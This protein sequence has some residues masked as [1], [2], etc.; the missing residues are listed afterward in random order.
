K[1]TLPV[2]VEKRVFND[3]SQIGDW[4]KDKVYSLQLA[5]IIDGR[6]NGMFAPTASATRAEVSKMLDYYLQLIKTGTVE[7]TI[8]ETGTYGTSGRG[9]NLT[10]TSI[11][12]PGY[13]HTAIFVFEQHGFEDSYNR[14]G[15][16]LVDLAKE[17]ISFLNSNID[18]LWDCRVIIISSANPDGLAEGTTKNGPGRCTVAN[19]TDMNR[20]WPTSNYEPQTSNPRYYSPYALSCPET[21]NLKQLISRENPSV[22]LD[23][24]GWLN[25]SYGNQTL[26]YIF[27]ENMGLP[28][29]VLFS[30]SAGL[31]ANNVTY[32]PQQEKEMAF[33]SGL[34]G[35]KGYLAGYGKEQGMYSALIELPSPYNIN[36][37]GF[38]KAIENSIYLCSQS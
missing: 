1:I 29:K 20:D 14:D 30:S 13:Q 5:G 4:A 37:S 2:L 7:K 11:Y 36:K 35:F 21:R 25:G 6:E 26:A 3:D 23:I 10:Y 34:V 31:S 24:H 18:R 28:Y 15:Q 8:V 33:E 22:L 27:K 12:R 16:V 17:T 19:R 9:R 38:F 32:L